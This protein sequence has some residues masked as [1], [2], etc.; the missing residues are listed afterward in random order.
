MGLEPESAASRRRGALNE[1][2]RDPAGFEYPEVGGFPGRL[3]DISPISTQNGRILAGQQHGAVRSGETRQ[4]AHILRPG[5]QEPIEIVG[6]RGE[7]RGTACRGSPV[8]FHVYYSI[9]VTAVQR[10][11][12]PADATS[13]AWDR[14]ALDQ[15]QGVTSWHCFAGSR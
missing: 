3:Q 2:G 11:D 12:A 7:R 15:H 14:R 6:Q 1:G 4:I 10:P 5:H 8:R 13:N 9:R